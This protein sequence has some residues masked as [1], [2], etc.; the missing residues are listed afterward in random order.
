MRPPICAVCANRFNPAKGGT[1]TFA[2]YHPLPEGMVGHPA[3]LEW[4]CG[5]HIEAARHLK[6][7]SS[8]EAI[9]QIKNGSF[10]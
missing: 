8:G 4:F 10:N 7:L 3:G 6:H 2:N 5:T 9:K 1:V